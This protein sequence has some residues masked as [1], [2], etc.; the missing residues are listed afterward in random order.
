MGSTKRTF[1]QE[2]KLEAVRR[3][4]E[5]Q[6]PLPEVSRE[7]GVRPDT[8][9]RWVEAAAGTAGL[10]GEAIAPGQ[11]PLQSKD[12]EIQRLRAE[13]ELMKQERDFLK[14]A[15]AYFAKDPR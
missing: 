4:V 12:L 8:L 14:K 15:A 9:R 7:L 6:H 3:I 11:R 1:T 13:L 10:G 2:F 5:G